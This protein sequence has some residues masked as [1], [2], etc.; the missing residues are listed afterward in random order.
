MAAN[1]IHF[2]R[3]V[4]FARPEDAPP[5]APVAVDEQSEGNAH[6][7]QL[8]ERVSILIDMNVESAQVE[9][10]V[11]LPYGDDTG[12]IERKGEHF[13][14]RSAESRLEPVERRHFF[15]AGNAPGGPEVEKDHSPP[16]VRE[17][18]RRAGPVNEAKIRNCPPGSG[19]L[20]R[21]GPA[22]CGGFVR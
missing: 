22:R 16:E 14:F 15:A 17:R 19:P 18:A 1:P 4:P 5:L 6:A 8:A 20:G 12:L 3:L 7:A 13:E 2:R 9:L 21:G 10:L 11:E